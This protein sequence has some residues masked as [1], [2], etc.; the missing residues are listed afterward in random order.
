MVF[1]RR[2]WVPLLLA[3]VGQLA[4][5]AETPEGSPGGSG[6]AQ[7]TGGASATG[8]ASTGSGG[9]VGSGGSQPTT[10]GAPASGGAT[11]IATGGA[12]GSGGA[13][14][15]TG[16]G[17]G[18]AASGTG[19]AAGTPAPS[20]GIPAGYPAATAEN[21]AKCKT[22]PMSGG[23]CPGGGAGPVCLQ[24]LFGGTMF[25]ESETKPTDEG[26][27]LAGNYLVTLK[28]G[29]TAAGQTFVAAESSR[30]I[31]APTTT[32][33][34]QSQDYAFVVNVRAMEGQPLHKGG[35][36]GYP[37]LNLFFSGPTATPPQVAG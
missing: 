27:M 23:Y 30:G 9:G 29:G 3:L 11:P 13:S 20:V 31:L 4:C 22:V 12:V 37:G 15:A 32:A 35:P 14:A 26:T 17:A 36:S 28:L 8:G 25:G 7:S 21:V 16:G 2:S 18:G 10:G 6:G 1:T 5:V 24:C 33:A 19:G 34:G